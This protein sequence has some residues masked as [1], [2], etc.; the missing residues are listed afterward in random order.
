MSPGDVSTNPTLRGPYVRVSLALPD[1]DLVHAL[2]ERLGRDP[3]WVLGAL[4]RLDCWLAQ[5]DHS[6]DLRV[7]RGRL[8]AIVGWESRKGREML[9]DALI[10]H[11]AVDPERPGVYADWVSRWAPV[12]AKREADA[13]RQRA[14]RASRSPGPSPPSPPSPTPCAPRPA[15]SHTTA[16]PAAEAHAAPPPSEPAAHP[17]ASA[18]ASDVEGSPPLVDIE[19]N[20][21]TH[22]IPA[23][24]A[25][26][27][28]HPDEVS[29]PGSPA[30]CGYAWEA[31]RLYIGEVDFGRFRKHVRPMLTRYGFADFLGAVQ[32][33]R[34]HRRA[35]SREDGPE[36]LRF[37][38]LNAFL[39][40]A[41]NLVRL[42][43]QPIEDE[44]DRPTERGRFTSHYVSRK[45]FV[46]AS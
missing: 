18:E 44:H 11:L 6:G 7:L 20:G 43:H 38:T 46:R 12:R 36:G 33:W 10:D 21:V 34:A 9:A 3:T 29:D 16:S 15:T 42:S 26:A 31:W 22:R 27:L 35:V 24:A 8:P 41:E 32:V 4:V 19:W 40:Q 45:R 30:A 17:D 25:H 37:L 23:A 14:A 28:R 13:D 1:S 5:Q 2:A 39:E